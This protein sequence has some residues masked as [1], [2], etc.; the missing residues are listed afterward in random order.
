MGKQVN[1]QFAQVEPEQSDSGQ[2]VPSE[3]LSIRPEVQALIDAGVLAVEGS[4]QTGVYR[5]T[6]VPTLDGEPIEG[7]TFLALDQDTVR[8]MSDA[9]MR[10][11]NLATLSVERATDA[12]G[13]DRVA[14]VT[15]I[16]TSDASW[17]AQQAQD[18]RKGRS[19]S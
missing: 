1:I 10:H 5:L 7:L 16:R 4:P 17:V 18:E 11:Y 15:R 6:Q 2:S 13:K 19:A 14:K 12:N 9:G 8:G 3:W